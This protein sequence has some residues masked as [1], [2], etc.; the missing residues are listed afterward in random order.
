MK[1]WG[2]GAVGAAWVI[3]S[4]SSFGSTSADSAGSN[5]DAGPDGPTN[6]IGVAHAFTIAFAA[7]AAVVT[8]KDVTI[9]ITITRGGGATGPSTIT[10][11]GLA[12]GV[13]A[14]HRHTTARRRND[15]C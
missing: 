8:G 15:R 2:I 7:D 9:P 4:C 12:E 6:L 13:A 3:V 1:T 11:Q 10:V 14:M 5:G